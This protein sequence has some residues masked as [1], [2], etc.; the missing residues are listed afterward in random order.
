MERMI[1]QQ[2]HWLAVLTLLPIL[3]FVVVSR[4]AAV[5]PVATAATSM[6]LVLPK[7]RVESRKVDQQPA[8]PTGTTT[9]HTSIAWLYTS[10]RL[11]CRGPPQE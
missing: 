3:T 10:D 8:A 7:A 9:R 5:L 1:R 6:L 4:P 2:W 11:C